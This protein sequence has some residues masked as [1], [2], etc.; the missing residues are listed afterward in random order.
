MWT[1]HIYLLRLSRLAKGRESGGVRQPDGLAVRV[2]GDGAVEAV[3]RVR[4]RR[5]GVGFRE[6]GRVRLRDR[7]DDRGHFARGAVEELVQVERAGPAD[8]ELLG[9]GAVRVDGRFGAAE[10]RARPEELGV[11][12][13]ARV[14]ARHRRAARAGAACGRA[15]HFV[16]GGDVDPFA[17]DEQRR[18]VA[19]RRLEEVGD[20]R[21]ARRVAREPRRR[22]SDRAQ[23][24]EHVD[25]VLG[26]E[27]VAR[28][29]AERLR[30]ARAADLRDALADGA[31]CAEVDDDVARVDVAQQAVRRRGRRERRR[32]ARDR[33]RRRQLDDARR[34][35]LEGRAVGPGPAEAAR[36]DEVAGVE[37]VPAPLHDA[38]PVG[39]ELAAHRCPAHSHRERRRKSKLTHNADVR[40][41]SPA[42]RMSGIVPS[43]Y[44][45]LGVCTAWHAGSRS[46][47]QAH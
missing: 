9:R 38:D 34:V 43:G 42:H 40:L 18:R 22:R 1:R 4:Q 17:V 14:G 28:D 29:E 26:V 20:E 33:R 31:L 25:G 39:Q 23:V 10:R 30:A 47:E 19:R 41:P 3:E 15:Q 46:A 8:Q 13:V 5:V 6:D 35:G 11:A 36:V 2:L 32:R 44:R 37:A 27:D 45:T 21:A 16:D 12:D 24:L 7:G